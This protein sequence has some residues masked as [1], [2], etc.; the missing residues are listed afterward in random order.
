MNF[1]TPEYKY[2]EATVIIN[3]VKNKLSSYF[4]QGSLDE[5]LLY[6]V[7]K[8]CLDKIGYKIHPVKHKILE[9]KDRYADLPND[10]F[11]AVYLIGAAE[12]EMLDLPYDLSRPEYTETE[13]YRMIINKGDNS[14]ACQFTVPC[15]NG[16]ITLCTDNYGQLY[17]FTQEFDVRKVKFTKVFPIEVQDSG[18]L[19]LHKPDGHTPYFATIRNGGVY[20]NFN[21]SVYIEYL[22]DHYNEDEEMIVPDYTQITDWIERAMMLNCFEKLYLNGEGDVLQRMQFLS[23]SLQ[24][25]EAKAKSFYKMLEVQDIY[26]MS[27]VLKS[28]YNKFKRGVY[29]QPNTNS[30]PSYT[31]N[32]SSLDLR[33]TS[34]Y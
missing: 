31:Y 26:D 8:S 14:N 27:R 4:E 28:R 19:S 1:N 33:T 6:P 3:N 21:G 5:S 32:S 34:R 24:M 9:V 16:E 17:E 25:Y 29:G 2:I 12:H 22:Q 15:D 7:I 10:F 20:T 30:D 11:K 18:N 23:N 13:K